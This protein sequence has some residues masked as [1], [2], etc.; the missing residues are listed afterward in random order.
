M[1]NDL[2]TS[3]VERQNIL[4]NPYAVA[5]IEQAAGIR[6]VPFEGR[7]VL[8]KE[9]VAAFFGVST[10][11]IESYLEKY[12]RELAQNGYELLRDNRLKL[13]KKA[14][15][16]DPL[17]EANFGDIQK[18]PQ[19]GV[20]DFRAFLNLAMLLGES[21]RA[22]SLRQVILDIALDT[23]SA[24]SGG[25]TKYV[26]QRDE[27][28]IRVAFAGEAYRQEFVDALTHHVDM[29]KAK[30]PLYTD[31]V[32]KCIFLERARDYRKA[33]K[34]QRSDDTRDTFWS[35]IFTLV[36]SFETGLADWIVRRAT[37]LDRRLQ[38]V[39]VDELFDKF[40]NQAHWAPLLRDA[41]VKM[42]SRDN[43]LRGVS[44]ER[45]ADYI[46]AASPEDFER[47]IGEKSKT[48]SERLLEAEDVLK[49]L[50]D[51]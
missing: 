25:G 42:A 22:R 34:L 9:Q 50:K 39:E 30:Y 28:F 47:F 26:N 29:G 11:T 10:R 49:R 1:A 3:A 32:Y 31:R 18:V 24:R 48:F 17:S 35:E 14:A 36:S 46:D 27:D 45:L 21:E 4:N 5:E 15:S 20:F 40:A 38:P 2:T 7:G 23:V 37:E 8:V 6:G 16:A 41:R 43:A 51:R 13:F 12:G 44:H 19:I 33:L